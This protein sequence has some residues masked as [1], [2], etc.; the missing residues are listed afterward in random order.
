MCT[1]LSLASNKGN[2]FFGRNMDI[3]CYFN[4]QVMIVPER[5]KY[6]NK[7]TGELVTNK[8][9]YI[10][11]GTII[12][13]HPAMAEAM[14][15]NGLACAGLNFVGYAHYEKEPVK[16]KNNIAPYD[17]IQWVVSGYDTV[18]EVKSAIKEIELVE[19]PIK[20]GIKVAN[21]HWMITDK[22]GESIVVEK[23]IEGIRV[24]DNTVGVMTNNPTFDWQ[25]TN[26]NEYI[27]L[28]QN[29]PEDTMW[30]EQKLKALGVGAGT[31]GIPGDFG[32]VSRFIR[33]AYIRAKKPK[34]NNNIEAITQFF[35]MLDYAKMI[36]GGVITRDGL[37]DVTLYSSCMDQENAIYYYKTYKNSRISGINMRNEKLDG[38]DIKVFPY[39]DEQDIQYQN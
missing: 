24:Y 34:I 19:V 13:S 9:A 11:M 38:E 33:M 29:Q 17:F 1:A 6:V 20:E 10:G 12:D 2:N 15:E 36:R 5:Y 37:E 27:N 26:L 4:Q 21:L 32:S 7:V 39:Q 31:R 14:N 30:S 3:E 22:M 35:H 8:K 25:I 16:D 23:T 28:S 18:Q